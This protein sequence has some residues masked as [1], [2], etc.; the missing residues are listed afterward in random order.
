[1]CHREKD[2][3]DTPPGFLADGPW[4]RALDVHARE[5]ARGEKGQHMNEIKHGIIVACVVNIDHQR[6][7][8]FV[9]TSYTS[10]NKY[11]RKEEPI[12]SG[13]IP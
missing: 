4:L 11:Q 8:F 7:C 3:I 9:V 12:V 13:S 2:I 1:M 10:D 6:G 5:L